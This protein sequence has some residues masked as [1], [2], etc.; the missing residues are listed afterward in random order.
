MPCDQFYPTL[1]ERFPRDWCKIQREVS[2]SMIEAGWCK[3]ASKFNTVM[4]KKA[5]KLL[6]KKYCQ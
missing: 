4:K 2:D 1:E 6:I 5:K 3:H